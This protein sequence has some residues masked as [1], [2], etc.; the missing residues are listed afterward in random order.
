MVVAACA[1]SASPTVFWSIALFQ[2]ELLSLSGFV[3]HFW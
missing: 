3:V 2:G 1:G